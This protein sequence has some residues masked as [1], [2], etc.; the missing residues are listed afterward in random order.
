M[1]KSVLLFLIAFSLIFYISCASSGV[2]E[3]E[4]STTQ[5]SPETT[6]KF[7]A[8]TD[9]LCKKHENIDTLRDCLQLLS[10]IRSPDNRN[11]EVEWK[12]ARYNYFFSKLADKESEID[13]VLEDGAN[14]GKIASR[15]EPNKPDGYFWYGA[16][17]GEQAKRAPLTKGLTSVDEIREA[18]NKVIEIQPDY[19]GASA[20]DALAQL[21]L[22]TRLTGGK[23]EKAVEY[24]EKALQLEKA[25]SFIYLHL[26]EAYLALNRD[27]EAKKQIDLLLQ[28]KP[29]PDYLPEYE[30]SKKKAQEL[31]KSKF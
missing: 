19:Q 12:F 27:A 16:N 18:M 30:E 25:N 17:L 24:L 28:M 21:E 31:L 15:I 14:A 23:A 22:A 20:Y 6:A 10:Q 2:A 9:V 26:A 1:S 4:T 8:K 7:L 5:R 29:N 13:K 11:Y 3:V